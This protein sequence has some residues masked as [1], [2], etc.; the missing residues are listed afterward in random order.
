MTNRL[1]WSTLFISVKSTSIFIK[2]FREFILKQNKLERCHKTQIEVELNKLFTN[3]ESPICILFNS[4]TRLFL[5]PFYKININQLEIESIDS[6]ISLCVDDLSSFIQISQNRLINLLLPNNLRNNNTKIY[7]LFIKLI[8]KYIYTYCFNSSIYNTI[9]P[10]YQ[11]IHHNIDQKLYEISM[12]SIHLTTK[13]YQISKELQIDVHYQNNNNNN[14]SILQL[15]SSKVNI[16]QLL[17]TSKTT[18]STTSTNIIKSPFQPCIDKLWEMSYCHTPTKKLQCLVEL[19]Q[20][21]IKSIDNYRQKQLPL[22]NNDDSTDDDDDD[23]DDDD[24]EEEKKEKDNINENEDNED[25]ISI[26]SLDYISDEEEYSENNNNKIQNNRRTH[27][28]VIEDDN[29]INVSLI[30][31][32]SATSEYWTQSLKNTTNKKTKNKQMKIKNKNKKK[33][34]IK[35]AI[36]IKSK[37]ENN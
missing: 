13:N 11:R 26:E 3:N 12:N 2:T 19:Q 29:D 15:D 7:K 8:K 21:L 16:N 9:F 1:K 6:I 20:L 22:I 33:K 18:T 17:N 25:G 36:H 35:K 10:L 4:F 5:E 37:I 32:E 34:K 14:D 28:I 30:S 27:G 24:Y 23:D 31:Y